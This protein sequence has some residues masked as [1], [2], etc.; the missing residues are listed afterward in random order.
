LH[1]AARQ[2]RETAVIA[3]LSA[4]ALVGALAPGRRTVLHLAA[5]WGTAGTVILL[6]EAGADPGAADADGATPA[7]VAERCGRPVVAAMLRR[8][9]PLGLTATELEAI[10]GDGGGGM[11]A[12]WEA[13]PDFEVRAQVRLLKMKEDVHGPSHPALL[14]TLGRLAVLRRQRGCLEEAR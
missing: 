8:W 10:G 1:G 7:D 5:G 14:A 11:A 6:L 13:E 2:G 12:P 3:L 4:G 9:A